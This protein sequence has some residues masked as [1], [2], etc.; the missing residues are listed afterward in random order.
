MQR[1]SAMATADARMKS[2]LLE[3]SE[4]MSRYGVMSKRSLA[5]VRAL[6]ALRP[7]KKPGNEMAKRADD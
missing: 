7:K 3:L 4:A 1:K 5:K 2:G 6:A